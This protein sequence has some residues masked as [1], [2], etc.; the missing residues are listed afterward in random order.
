MVRNGTGRGPD[1]KYCGEF[2]KFHSISAADILCAGAAFFDQSGI[3]RIAFAFTG[4]NRKVAGGEK[5]DG[6]VRRTRKS[7]EARSGGQGDWIC[8]RGAVPS[9][10]ARADEARG[11]QTR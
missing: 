8:A 5:A 6:G 11:I 1:R 4:A 2:Q 10:R 9:A 3:P 7:G